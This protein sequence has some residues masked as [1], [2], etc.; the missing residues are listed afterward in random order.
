MAASV[1]VKKNSKYKK[2]Y[3]KLLK[4]KGLPPLEF[5]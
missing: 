4:E 1:G 2:K 5:E 3:G